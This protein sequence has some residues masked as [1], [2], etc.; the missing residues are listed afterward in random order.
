M[1]VDMFD[2]VKDVLAFV[3]LSAFSVTALLWVDLLRTL[4]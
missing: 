1:E 2:L 3:S 4:A